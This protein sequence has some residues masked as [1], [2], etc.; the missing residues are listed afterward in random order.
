M[1]TR[2]YTAEARAAGILYIIATGAIIASA[3]FVGSTDSVEFL[4][5]SAAEENQVMLGTLLQLAW[6]LS[7]MFIPVV[8]FRVLKLC[9]GI[10]ALGFFSLRFTE[11]LLSLIYVVLQLTMLRLS[12]HYVNGVDDASAYEA[13]AVLLLEARDWAFAMGA[14]FAFN[15]SAL[16]LNYL[17]YRSSIV[18]RWL[19]IWG[20][21]GA[22]LWMVMWFP[23]I[24]DADLGVLEAAFVPIAVQE[25]VFAVY[26]I[27]K[28][29]DPA[30]IE[31]L[32][33]ATDH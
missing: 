29:F 23:Q 16:L 25:M 3:P 6:V 20:L 14:G 30:A 27:V 13:S 22:V 26:L 33:A 10:G 8:L 24:F 21:V 18:P 5:N 19:S 31:T 15:L 9:S 2:T 17:L 32:A 4:S 1:V 7:V 12:K 11:A 28:G